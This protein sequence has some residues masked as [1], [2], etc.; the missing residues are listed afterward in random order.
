MT[1]QAFLSPLA[2]QFYFAIFSAVTAFAYLLIWVVS[3]K[4]LI[5]P[6]RTRNYFPGGRTME[7]ETVSGLRGSRPIRQR[8]TNP[9][10]STAFQRAHK[11]RVARITRANARAA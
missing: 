7:K 2:D 8:V 1:L 9:R 3:L 10:T 11:R 5:R 6:V 4:G